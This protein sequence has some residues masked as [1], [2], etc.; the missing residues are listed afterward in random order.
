MVPKQIEGVRIA[1]SS[2]TLSSGRV[3]NFLATDLK[4]Y[5]IQYAGGPE[6]KNQSRLKHEQIRVIDHSSSAKF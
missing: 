5:K 4:L 6:L 1:Y 3:V 2:K